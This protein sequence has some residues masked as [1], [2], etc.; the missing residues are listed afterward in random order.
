MVYSAAPLFFYLES[1]DDTHL[2]K[3]PVPL[4]EFK[5]NDDILVRETYLT[6][7]YEQKKKTKQKNK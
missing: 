6:S 4:P 7:K 5:L 3:L 1:G 2:P